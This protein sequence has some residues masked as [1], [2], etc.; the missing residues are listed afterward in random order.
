MAGVDDISRAAVTVD[1]VDTVRASSASSTK[2]AEGPNRA[3]ADGVDLA[4]N[5]QVVI[6]LPGLRG[7][8]AH[9]CGRKTD[10]DKL[11]LG[12][13]L[14]VDR[15]LLAQADELPPEYI[16]RNRFAKRGDIRG[17]V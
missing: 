1:M 4:T 16:F 14:C 8:A 7:S 15:G 12:Q 17:D 9:R 11:Q 2:I 13:P 5:G 6:G 3:M 10:P